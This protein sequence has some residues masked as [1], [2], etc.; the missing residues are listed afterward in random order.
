M[1]RTQPAL[2][3]G[4]WDRNDIATASVDPLKKAQ[5]TFFAAPIRSPY[6]QPSLRKLSLFIGP[7]KRLE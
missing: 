1:K 3:S 4:A 5:S 7:F 2:N 6:C